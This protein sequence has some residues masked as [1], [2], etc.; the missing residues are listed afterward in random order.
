[1]VLRAVEPEARQTLAGTDKRLIAC[2]KPYSDHP[3][4]TAFLGPEDS[5]I[6]LGPDAA[7]SVIDA[8]DLIGRADVEDTVIE[9]IV[10]IDQWDETLSPLLATLRDRLNR[11]VM[12]HF[13][14]GHPIGGSVD[15]RM[16]SLGFTRQTAAEPMYLF[17]I[18]T[19]KQTPDWLNARHWANPELWGKYRW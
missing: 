4:V 9:L 19:Y 2:A 16:V 15:Q 3:R 14:E 10:M 1:M 7:T 5:M 18:E 6:A 13:G 11:P 8:D 17:D 12:V